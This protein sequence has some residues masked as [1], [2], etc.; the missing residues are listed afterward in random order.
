MGEEDKEPLQGHEGVV[1]SLRVIE[2][3]GRIVS[4]SRNRTVRVSK[5]ETREAAAESLRGHED[6]VTSVG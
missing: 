5:M 6:R 2:D 3:G 1:L 4:G